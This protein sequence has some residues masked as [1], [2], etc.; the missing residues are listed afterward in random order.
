MRPVAVSTTS[1]PSSSTSIALPAPPGLQRMARPMVPHARRYS[2]RPHSPGPR[3]IRASKS[4]HH[5]EA[6]SRALSGPGSVSKRLPNP[7]GGSGHQRLTPSP[8]TTRSPEASSNNP[9]TLASSRS[10]SFGHL[11]PMSSP[12]TARPAR[13]A[14]SERHPNCAAFQPRGR[15]A[16]EAAIARGAVSHRRPPRPRPADWRAATTSTGASSAR[17]TASS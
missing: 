8:I 11:Q 6:S 4:S 16:S 10:K 15:I 17:A 7:A 14:T 13:A 5:P 1:L 12:R 3:S 2:A 9:A